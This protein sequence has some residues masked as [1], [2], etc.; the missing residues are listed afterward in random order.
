MDAKTCLP[1]IDEIIRRSRWWCDT[2]EKMDFSKVENYQ[3]KFQDSSLLHD[4][5][6]SFEGQFRYMSAFKRTAVHLRESSCVYILK[7]NEDKICFTRKVFEYLSDTDIAFFDLFEESSLVIFE[8]GKVFHNLRKESRVQ[9]IMLDVLLP[10]WF[11]N[12]NESADV[13]T[14]E[15]CQWNTHI[16]VSILRRK[17]KIRKIVAR[18]ESILTSFAEEIEKLDKFAVTA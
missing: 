3:Q 13:Y 8:F 10:E 4:F 16:L 18:L 12:L 15:P 7:K 11:S 1:E 17:K 6:S 2:L 5:L 14:E 9:D